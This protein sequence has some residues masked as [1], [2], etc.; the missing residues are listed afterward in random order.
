MNQHGALNFPNFSANDI[1]KLVL[2]QCM[3]LK[4][5]I[6]IYRGGDTICGLLPFCLL[7]LGDAY[8]GL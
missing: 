1:F 7:V 3:I 4:R 2:L 5:K 6:R 8:G